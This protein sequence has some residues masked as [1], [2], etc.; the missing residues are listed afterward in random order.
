MRTRITR[1]LG[2]EHPILLSGMNYVTEPVLVAA[3]SN[4][5]GLGLLSCSHFTPK[6]TLANIKEI[7]K[8]TNKP[9]GL[10]ITIPRPYAKEN[11]EIAVEEKVP[12]INY[13]LGKP[14]F[15]EQVHGYGGKVIG[16]VA[17]S[18]H[19]ARAE[20]LG[21][22]ALIIT[23][24]EAAAHGG[25]VTSLVLI[26]IVAD[27]VRIPFISAG[28]FYDGRGLAAA[29]V[30]GA[31]GIAMGTRFIATR[32]SKVHD[33]F[34]QLILQAT[35][36][37]TIRTSRIDGLPSRV[38]RTAASERLI[39]GRMPMAQALKSAFALKRELKLSTGQFLRT[40]MEMRKSE[41]SS[42]M[43]QAR[44]AVFLNQL[45]KAINGDVEEGVFPAGQVAGA[46]HDI[47]SCDELIKRIVSDAEKALKSTGAFFS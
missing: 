40:S 18:K 25:E 22:D 17:T 38:L 24:H 13:S 37:D 47:V 15:I 43:S 39:S 31:S 6:G 30:L 29:L 1:L 2:I 32:E 45:Q 26:P 44:Q 16:S 12:V 11:L 21:A 46:I 33:S 35:E 8:L 4:S 36:E 19:A 9:F 42:A 23:G 10:T 34:K 14:W 20:Q 27:L 7:R 3:V 28:G 41:G 5:G